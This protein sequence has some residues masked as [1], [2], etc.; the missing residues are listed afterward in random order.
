[1]TNLRKAR[2]WPY[3]RIP[4]EVVDLEQGFLLAATMVCELCERRAFNLT[5]AVEIVGMYG[6][7]NGQD[8]CGF[9]EVCKVHFV[10]VEWLVTADK[11]VD[12]EVRSLTLLMAREETRYFN[13]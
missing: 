8:R 5:S 1:M 3:I 11:G 4:G 9:E 2:K 10:N 13:K 12:I 6:R 7:G